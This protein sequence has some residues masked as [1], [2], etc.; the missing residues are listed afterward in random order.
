MPLWGHVLTGLAALAAARPGLVEVGL[1]WPPGVVAAAALERLQRA[2]AD[3]GPVRARRLA[4]LMGAHPRLGEWGS[5]VEVCMVVPGGGC[6]MAYCHGEAEGA[7]GRL[8][9]HT[10]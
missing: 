3:P 2:A 6:L 4:V 7:G 5:G 8:C 1:S 9:L 10:L